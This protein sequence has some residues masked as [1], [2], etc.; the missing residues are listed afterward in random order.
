MT[1]A[2]TLVLAGTALN[3]NAQGIVHFEEIEPD[4]YFVG[5]ATH[6]TVFLVTAEGIIL[7]DPTN[8]D[9]SIELKAEIEQRFDVPVRY[10]LYSHHH[11]DHVSGG[12]VWEDTA[13]FIG[14]ENMLSHFERLPASTPLPS[15]M[16][17]WDANG[18]GLI[19]EV[20]APDWTG[21]NTVSRG[22]YLIE[23]FIG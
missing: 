14:H 3:V 17:T 23:S 4:L 11:G 9:F 5:N 18:N 2:A 15:E 7:A 22:P 6:N 16:V 19:E 10:V 21:F 12:V 20:E 13:L 1:V 8:R